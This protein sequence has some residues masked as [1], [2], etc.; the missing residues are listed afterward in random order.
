MPDIRRRT[1]R[2]GIACVAFA[3]ALLL[4]LV[5]TPPNLTESPFLLF[6]TA[7]AISAWYGGLGPGLLTT[8]LA[9][10][11]SAVVFLPPMLVLQVDGPT[12]QIR[13]ALFVLEGCV[14]SGFSGAL[15]RAHSRATA[16]L[17][18]RDEFVQV[19]AHELKTPLTAL[20]GYVQILQR[21]APGARVT[22]RD[23]RSVA[24]ISAQTV[25]LNRLI[26]SLLDLTSIQG[27]RLT[28]APRLIDL[29]GLTRQVVDEMESTLENH[30]L[31]FHAPACP[32]EVMADALRMEQA[33]QNLLQNAVKYSP[34]GGPIIVRVE[35]NA[36][37]ASVSVCDSGI[38][39]GP[40]ELPHIFER[41]YRGEIA[42]LNA[43]GLGIGLAVVREIAR[44]HQGSVE[45][46]SAKGTGSTFTLTVPLAS[47]LQTSGR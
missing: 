17:R 20:L 3:L 9:T 19:A 34:D 36:T 2:Y 47:P 24:S 28:I 44:M 14:I 4:K 40:E 37:T 43:R 22:E 6:F 7:V 1:M 26:E 27:G 15:H 25:R 45:V 12:N 23:L 13:L 16:A 8:G 30:T 42:A 5:V 35:T 38:G 41:Y 31:Q 33:V 11:G 29:V 32:V 46:L 10:L 39:I 21:R 18:S